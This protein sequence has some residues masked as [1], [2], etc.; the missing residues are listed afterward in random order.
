MAD[1]T[2]HGVPGAFV[3]MLGMSILNEVIEDPKIT[4]ASGIL[5]GMRSRIKQALRQSSDVDSQDD[6]M[7]MALCIINTDTLEMQA[8]CANNSIYLI[9]NKQLE[10]IAPTLN[11]VGIYFREIPFVNNV[12]QLQ[13][14][15]C[16]YLFTDGFTD[17]F[18][19]TDGRRFMSQNFKQMILQNFHVPMSVQKTIYE[20][21]LADWQGNNRQVDD[22]SL[23]GIRI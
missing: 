20:K 7:D 9:R 1:S 23:L 2:G 6:G 14:G 8:A 21:R 3:S 10:I 12:I 5:E 17:Q 4:T 13:K 16:L 19:G 15:D 22:I 11:P 18:G